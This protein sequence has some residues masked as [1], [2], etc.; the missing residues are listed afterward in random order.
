MLLRARSFSF[1][2][3]VALTSASGRHC[4]FSHCFMPTSIN[5]RPGVQKEDIKNVGVGVKPI[6]S[7]LFLSKQ[8]NYSFV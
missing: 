6:C 3:L 2:K 5:G 4:L 8:G 7:R 1:E